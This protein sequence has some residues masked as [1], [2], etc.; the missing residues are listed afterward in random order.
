MIIVHPN[1]KVVTVHKAPTDSKHI[2][3]MLN[4][5][6]AFSA[7]KD[8]TFNE[9]RVFVYLSLNQPEYTMA[10]STADMV[11]RVGSTEDG[12]RKAIQ[13]LIQ[14][15][16]LVQNSGRNYDFYEDPY[17]SS[18][19][20]EHDNDETADLPQENEVLTNGKDSVYPDEKGGEIIQEN[21]LKNTTNYNTNDLTDTLSPEWKLI[22]DRIKVNCLPH[23]MDKLRKAA[24]CD[25]DSRVIRRIV[26]Q[27]WSK[28]EKQLDKP[29]GYR[30]STLANFIGSQYEKWKNIIAME[31]AEYLREMEEARRKP[32]INYDAIHRKEPEQEGLGDISAL[33]E[34][35]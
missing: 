8:L 3:G 28:F 17:D 16:Y 31:N 34:E 2:Y 1:Q 15:G 32:R 23:T 35:F 6:A 25:P 20:K 14:K 29:E 21:T 19:V 22:F 5:Q 4:K 18:S 26:S 13:G 33:L 10:L 9:V 7:L 24:G 11:V 30:L 27:N 12:L